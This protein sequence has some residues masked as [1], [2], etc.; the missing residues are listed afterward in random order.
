MARKSGTWIDQIDINFADM[1]EEN[2]CI[3]YMKVYKSTI[4]N[5]TKHLKN[6]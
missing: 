3:D 4:K 2:I 6:M 1:I 5:T